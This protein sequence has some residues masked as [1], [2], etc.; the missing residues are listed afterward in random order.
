[1]RGACYHTA[2]AGGGGR[3]PAP[4]RRSLLVPHTP[5]PGGESGPAGSP[6]TPQVNQSVGELRHTAFT[7]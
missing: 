6:A 7:R 3:R 4:L 5:E 2:G 1:M